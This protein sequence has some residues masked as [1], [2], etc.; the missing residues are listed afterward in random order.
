MWSLLDKVPTPWAAVHEQALYPLERL[1]E[2]ADAVGR[3]DASSRQREW[4]RDSNDAGRYWAAVGLNARLELSENDRQSL[5]AALATGSPVVRIEAAVAL[6][7]HGDADI[8]LPVLTGELS[9]IPSEVALH[10]ARALELL[11]RIA[12]PAHAEMQSALAAAREHEARGDD[13]AMF[14]RFSLEGALAR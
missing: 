1:L 14:I 11:G 5:R 8:A 9:N 3:E 6:A 12:R 4:L 13:L 10:A 2:V 7:R